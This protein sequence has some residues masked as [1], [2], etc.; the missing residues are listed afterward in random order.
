MPL[1]KPLDKGQVYALTLTP[2]QQAAMLDCI[3][4]TGDMLWLTIEELEKRICPSRGESI[5]EEQRSR[6]DSQGV[7]D[8]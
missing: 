4:E 3:G 6:S 7:Q 2:E 5:F 1:D 8:L